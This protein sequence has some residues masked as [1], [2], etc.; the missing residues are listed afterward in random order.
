MKKVGIIGSGAVGKV[1]AAGFMK[2]GY[3]VMI[4]TRD[5]SKLN[6]WV[7]K[8]PNGKVGSFA[9]TAAYGEIIVLAVKGI[10]ATEALNLCE[11]D[12]LKGKAVIDA[13]NPIGTSAPIN[14]V[15]QYFTD[16]KQSLMEKLQEQAKEAHFVKAFNSVGSAFMVD[17]DF[18]GVKPSMFIC[19]NNDNAKAEV[20]L[21]LDKFGWET[22]DMGKANAA[23]SIEQLCV[24]WCIRGFSS[25]QW[26]HAFKLLKK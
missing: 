26:S 3:S 5:S 21:I 18:G 8:N 19:G 16:S 22:E 23:G 17:P 20:K 12:N 14:G 24:L 6:E 2:Y 1:L 10:V 25:N 9:E 11:L 15:L 7:Q 4:G 13:T